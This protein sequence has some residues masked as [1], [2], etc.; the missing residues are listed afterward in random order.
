MTA[1]AQPG[2]PRSRGSHASEAEEVPGRFHLL[3]ATAALIFT[4]ANRADDG[5]DN[6]RGPDGRPEEASL[7]IQEELARAV[8]EPVTA[9][10][11]LSHGGEVVLPGLAGVAVKR[12][13]LLGV[14]HA[15]GVQDVTA[16]PELGLKDDND[17]SGRLGAC[18]RR[19][20]CAAS[21]K[22]RRGN[23]QAKRFAQFTMTPPS[24]CDR[25]PRSRGRGHGGHYGYPRVV[26]AC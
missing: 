24:G 5:A 22:S 7:A 10:E 12:G 13:A 1:R 16:R 20:D 14:E 9:P 8:D 23:E 19:G 21:C 18:N 6:L 15:V 11:G 3:K 17:A 4:E 25:C 26:M 2:M